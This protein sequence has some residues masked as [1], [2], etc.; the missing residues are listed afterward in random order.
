MLGEWKARQLP[1]PDPNYYFDPKPANFYPMG[2]I[3]IENWTINEG[4]FFDNFIITHSLQAAWNFAKYTFEPKFQ[5]ELEHEKLP[6]KRL[7]EL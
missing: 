2:G 5:R 4:L 6:P 3:A 1:N 7:D